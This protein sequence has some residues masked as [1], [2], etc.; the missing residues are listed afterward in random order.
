MVYDIL[1]DYSFVERRLYYIVC[2]FYTRHVFVIN[3]IINRKNETTQQLNNY[4]IARRSF[5]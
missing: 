2:V 5:I 1:F 3:I 4:M